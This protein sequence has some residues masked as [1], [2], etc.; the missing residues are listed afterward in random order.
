MKPVLY[1]FLILLFASGCSRS[2]NITTLDVAQFEKQLKE[3]ADKII[4]DVRTPEEYS[5]GH[6]PGSVMID[7]YKSDFR[8]Q[9]NK[10]DKT[11]PVFVYCASGVRSSSAAKI[12]VQSGFTQVFNLQGGINA[13]YRS[14]KPIER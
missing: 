11:K 10:L 12:L 1:S 2:Q 4:L 7:Y 6:I 13:W 14:G 8:Q 3:K 5:D 9:I